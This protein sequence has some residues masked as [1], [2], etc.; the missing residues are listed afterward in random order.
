MNPAR[1]GMALFAQARRDFHDS[2]LASVLHVSKAGVPSN[3][4]KHNRASVAIAHGIIQRLVHC[5][6]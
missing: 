2:L 6:T 3:A 5:K 1:D 4:D